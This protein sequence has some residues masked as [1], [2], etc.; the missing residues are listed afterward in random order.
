MYEFNIL[1]YNHIIIKREVNVDM[2]N[3]NK[4]KRTVDVYPLLSGII[5]DMILFVPVNM[6]YLSVTKGLTSAEISFVMT[7][8]ILIAILMQHQCV[9]LIHNIG[10][11]ISLRLGILIL[12]ASCIVLIFGKSV[13]SFIVYRT[14]F[15]VAYMFISMDTIILR[16]NLSFFGREGEY[17]DIR[18]RANMSYAF[19][20]MIA[21]LIAGAFFNISPYLPLYLQFGI[22][23]IG[24]AIAFTMQEAPS[25]D[26]DGAGSSVHLKD[27]TTPVVLLL[28]Y[29]I[30]CIGIINNGQDNSKLFMQYDF[31]ETISMKNV[32]MYISFIVFLSRV[33]RMVGTYIFGEL[34]KR[35]KDKLLHVLSITLYL[36]FVFLVAGHLVHN[37]HVKIVIMGFGFCLILAMRDAVKIFI[38]DKILSAYDEK[39]QQHI[40]ILIGTSRAIGTLVFSGVITCILT[41]Q[42]MFVVE[43]LLLGVAAINVVFGIYAIKKHPITA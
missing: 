5:S 18:A 15:E 22:L 38:E 23:I 13:F 10:D 30:I 20:T 24:L 14:L 11:C 27:L 43:M 26:A 7:V 3:E 16:K 32:T 33:A 35:I 8:S 6:I 28:V 42:D 17:F 29:N 25:P 19:L 41:R 4:L 39:L 40:L 2:S 9:K 31:G 21:S 36:A 34:Y 37:L 12:M 1:C